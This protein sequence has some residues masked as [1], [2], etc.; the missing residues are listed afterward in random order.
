M[1]K[2]LTDYNPPYPFYEEFEVDLNAISG[3]YNRIGRAY[4][5]VSANGA[6]FRAYTSGVDELWYGSSLA[7]PL[8][9][10]VLVLVC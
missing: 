6:N 2:Y 10:S 1:A 4:P 9:A 5:D 3:I 7:S 8:F